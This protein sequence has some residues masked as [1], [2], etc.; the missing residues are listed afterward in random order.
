[1][2]EGA[3]PG[4]PG[5]EAAAGEEG[6]EVETEAGGEQ[7]Q[8]QARAEAGGQQHQHR[9][10]HGQQCHGCSGAGGRRGEGAAPRHQ[11]RVLPLPLRPLLAAGGGAGGRAT[12]TAVLTRL[13]V[14]RGAEGV[15]CP[16]PPWPC[17]SCSGVSPNSCW[18]SNT[19]GATPELLLL[20]LLVLL[21]FCCPI[22]CCC[23]C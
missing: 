3:G 8:R 14:W 2:R 6:G 18:S 23:C 20:L 9:R 11:L 12:P 22:P 17:C 4:E 15:S 5:Q 19:I 1:M 21:L 13:L 10:Q 7:Q 16:C